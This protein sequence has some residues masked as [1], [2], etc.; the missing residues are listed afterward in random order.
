ME[1]IKNHEKRHLPHDNLTRKQREALKKLLQR[2]DLII[3]RADK[4]GAIVIWGIDEYLKEANSQSSNTEFYEE[5]LIDPLE[6]HQKLIVNS[7]NEML[8]NNIIDK[9]T[10]DMLKYIY[11]DINN[12]CPF[13]A[14][15][16]DDIFLIYTGGET[17]LDEF[18][19]SLNTKHDS[20]PRHLKESSP[21]SQAL[22]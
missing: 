15:Y 14:R 6:D 16:I 22:R 12:D 1:D 21:Y 18:L 17:K 7:L 2:N 3:T 8:S 9:E 11:P 4:G 10:S 20:H 19:T 13:Y 5:L